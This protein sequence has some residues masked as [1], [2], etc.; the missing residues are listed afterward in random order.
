MIIEIRNKGEL[1]NN[2]KRIKP[3]NELLILNQQFIIGL[4]I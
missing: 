3:I 1:I 2:K 4:M